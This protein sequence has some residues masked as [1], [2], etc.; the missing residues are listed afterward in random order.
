[1]DLAVPKIA[2]LPEARAE[3]IPSVA[4][5]RFGIDPIKATVRKRQAK[6][7]HIIRRQLNSLESVGLEFVIAWKALKAMPF[8]VDP[9]VDEV[10]QVQIDAQPRSLLRPV[11]HKA[12]V[13][14]HG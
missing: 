7:R 1:M 3:Q 8:A 12:G 10:V 6:G 13:R 9:Q 5:L 11:V 2:Q 4:C 14:Y